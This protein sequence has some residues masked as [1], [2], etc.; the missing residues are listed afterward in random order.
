[1]EINMMKQDAAET[2]ALQALAWLAANED[3]MPT[4]MGSTG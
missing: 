2:V 3:L 1:M 4:F